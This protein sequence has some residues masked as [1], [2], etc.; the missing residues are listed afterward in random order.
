MNI[1][2]LRQSLRE[3]WLGYYSDNRAWL[4]RLGIWVNVEG[5]RRPSSSFIL[6]TLSLLEPRLTQILPLIVDLNHNP[7]RIVAALGLNFN[8]DEVF[9][10]LPQTSDDSED[11]TQR[12]LPAS[13]TELA[14]FNPVKELTS[15]RR[16]VDETCRGSSGRAVEGDRRE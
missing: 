7:D 12:M 10:A 13:Q 3:Q 15:V 11:P 8:P 5:E 16:A 4:V 1:E 6:A 9:E 14:S 2:Q